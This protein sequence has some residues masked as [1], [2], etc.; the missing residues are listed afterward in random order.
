MIHDPPT[1]PPGENPSLR[2]QLL[3]TCREMSR[4][5]SHTLDQRPG[6]KLRLGMGIHLLFCR[7]CRRYSRQLGW[8]RSMAGSAPASAA[9]TVAVPPEEADAG[10]RERLRQ[11]LRQATADAPHHGP[12]TG[13]F[14]KPMP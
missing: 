11:R 5:T 1:G 2:A 4:H 3:P 8:L 14:P 9:A 7:L 10:R 6:W 12:T 13:N